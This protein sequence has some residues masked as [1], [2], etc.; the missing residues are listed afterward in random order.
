M[1]RN[2]KSV[3]RG[4]KVLLI[5]MGWCGML[6]TATGC[7]ATSEIGEV[8]LYDLSLSG[9]YWSQDSKY[10]SFLFSNLAEAPPSGPT[11]TN[12]Y[13]GVINVAS[14]QFQILQTFEKTYVQAYGWTQD[15]SLL[16]SKRTPQNTE[17]FFKVSLD[18]KADLLFDRAELKAFYN[19]RFITPFPDSTDLLAL[20]SPNGELPSLAYY[21]GQSK[22]VSPLDF[23]IPPELQVPVAAGQTKMMADILSSS[24][25]ICH[26]KNRLY[27]SNARGSSLSNGQ[28]LNSGYGFYHYY[29]DIDLEHKKVNNIK[30]FKSYSVPFKSRPGS[31]GNPEFLFIGWLSENE[32]LYTPDPS[33][34]GSERKKRYFKYNLVKQQEEEVMLPNYG[35]FVADGMISPDGSKIINTV[36]TWLFLYDLKTKQSKLLFDADVSMPKGAYR[37]AS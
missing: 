25:C 35:A 31:D 22:E 11:V 4:F 9:I 20:L 8:R 16:I 7:I 17:Q 24:F 34:R 27:F 18:G 3:F 6:I 13:L 15:N 23:P 37:T 33:L 2:T 19:A 29:A 12:F 14:G 5:L 28:D 30:L 26:G 10:I 21:N 32:M 36:S 1:K